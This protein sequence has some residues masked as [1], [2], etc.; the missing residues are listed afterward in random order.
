MTPSDTS[1]PPALIEAWW[2]SAQSVLDL[3]ATL[4]EEQLATPTDLPG[5]TVRDIIAHLAHLELELA[6]GPQVLAGD[7]EVDADALS[8]PFRAYTEKGVAAR[9]HRS[10]AYLVDELRESVDT[11]RATLT[12]P[13][14]AAPP[15]SFPR[16]GTTWEPLLRDRTFDYWMHE[17]DI[18]RAVGKPGGWD[19]PG[20]ALTLMVL[21]SSF[22]YV[23]GK[24]VRPPAGTTVALTVVGAG[25]GAGEGARAA[26]E[27]DGAAEGGPSQ[28]T[29]VAVGEDGRAR[30]G[31]VA[32]DE[33]DVH[34]TLSAEQLVLLGGGRRA[35]AVEDIA[36]SGD[37]D[38]ASQVLAAMPVT[39]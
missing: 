12:A 3:V 38:L 39:P 31:D 28:T 14:P 11:L 36:V 7:D 29:V 25:A 2:S 21:A 5:W 16:P 17:Q 33:A 34:L 6:G 18:R 23:V 32:A 13:E 8:D 30:A 27:G 10:V 4:D 20:A 22:P 15:A 9:Q 35:V 26:G 19:S 24:R 37:V 1:A